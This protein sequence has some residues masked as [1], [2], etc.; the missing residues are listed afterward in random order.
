MI[1]GFDLQLSNLRVLILFLKFC[2]YKATSVIL[3]FLSMLL[4]RNISNSEMGRCLEIN[5]NQ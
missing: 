1:V 2:Y 4:V 5:S 3:V